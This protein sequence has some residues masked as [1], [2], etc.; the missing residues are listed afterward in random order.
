MRVQGVGRRRAIA[1]GLGVLLGVL[2]LPASAMG[3]TASVSGSTFTFS[4]AGGEQNELRVETDGGLFRVIDNSAPVTA[5][6]G[7]IQRSVHRVNCPNAGVTLVEV[8]ARDHDD[9]VETLIGTTDAALNGG[10]GTD[11]LT[12]S[13][14]DDVLSAGKAGGGFFGETL[15]AGDGDDT[16]NGTTSTD[17]STFMVGGPGD[18]QLLGGRG[19]DT[20]FGDLG[21]DLLQ[22]GEGD[23]DSAFWGGTAGIN[24][25]MGSGANDGEPGEG[26]DVA[27]DIEQ[28]SGTQFNDTMVGTANV[29]SFFGG[30]GKDTLEGREGNDF[31]DGSDSA[32]TLEGEEGDDQL[33]GGPRADDFSGGPGQDVVGYGDHVSAV[34]VTIDNVANDGTGG[35]S[36]NVRTDVENLRGGDNNDTLI[37]SG[38][39]NRL[40]GEGGNDD[41]RGESGDDDVFGDFQFSGGTTGD[42]QVSGGNGDDR[43]AGGGGGDNFQGGDDFDFVDYSRHAGSTDLTITI[44]NVTNDGAAG[45]G[46]NVMDT[47]EG[48]VGANGNDTITAGAGAN[49]LFGGG[50]MDDLSGGNGPDLLDGETPGGFNTPAADVIN[51]GGGDDT[52]SYRSH[53][54][55]GVTVDIDGV[56]DDGEAGGAEG[57]NVQ[58]DVENL[59]GGDNSDSLTGDGDA[60][61]IAGRNG[62][63]TLVGGAGGD[64]LG[65][66][67]GSDTH[68]GQGGKDEI[69]SRNSDFG[70]VDNCGSEADVAI[71]D[72]GGVDT[73]N[74]CET[75]I[76]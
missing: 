67:F 51:G 65:G 40:E 1:A 43:L 54:F 45:E 69:N 76:P 24:V 6:A 47:V 62:S 3:A 9:T 25:T 34:T 29:E 74:N 72:G 70:D 19:Q 53:Q 10:S 71:I 46:D 61:T 22:G 38:Q 58:T 55:T 32:D 64:S 14:G 13:E 63:D 48:I 28:L 33:Q 35:E 41:V 21:A 66:G 68:E 39:D 16:L 56:A 8:L 75:V 50:G 31:L 18:D 27:A 57:D 59:I 30:A 73:T 2:V 17:R 37:G 23:F 11:E 4:A 26:D 60:N 7:C 44:D 12:S 15:F 36:D 20:L 42:D 5:G 49:T 52:A